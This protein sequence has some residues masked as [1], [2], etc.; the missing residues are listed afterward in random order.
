MALP[1]LYTLTQDLADWLEI[2]DPTEEDNA[3]IAIISGQIEKKAESICQFIRTLETNAEQFKAEEQRISNRRKALEHKAERIR[4]YIKQSMLDADI[5]KINAGTFKLSVALS[6]GSVVIDDINAVP[7]QYKTIIQEIK[8]DKKA[9]SAAI[10][11]K[12]DSVPGAHLEAGFVLRL[13]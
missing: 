5:T 13:S 4:A 3:L 1:A 6:P 7:P 9:I 12:P 8:P 11:Q 2:D 10:K